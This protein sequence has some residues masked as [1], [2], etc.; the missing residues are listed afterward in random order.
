[1]TERAFAAGM[2]HF[3]KAMA[4]ITWPTTKQEILDKVGDKKV[5]VSWT[6][7]KTIAEMISNIKVDEYETAPYFYNAYFASIF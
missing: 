1:M 5:K 7:E 6:E 4:D 2:H 3:H